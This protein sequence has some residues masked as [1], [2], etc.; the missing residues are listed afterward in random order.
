MKIALFA[1]TL[2]EVHAHNPEQGK[3][4]NRFLCDCLQGVTPDWPEI[5]AI[6]PEIEADCRQFHALGSKRRFGLSYFESGKF[7]HLL[8]SH[9]LIPE[10]TLLTGLA[11]FFGFGARGET[12]DLYVD[13]KGQAFPQ[14]TLRKL[15]LICVVLFLCLYL[16]F[17][18]RIS[19]VFAVYLIL[20]LLTIA[21]GL[22]ILYWMGKRV[23]VQDFDLDALNR[24]GLDQRVVNSVHK[25]TRMDK[26]VYQRDIDTISAQLL[27]EI[28]CLH[29]DLYEFRHLQD[30]QECQQAK[31]IFD[32]KNIRLMVCSNTRKALEGISLRREGPL[33]KSFKLRTFRG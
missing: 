22:Y 10:P 1:E 12:E 24:E 5:A 11:R 28:I 21:Y 13:F 19:M 7:S 25:L 14:Y 32:N 31:Q 16:Y 30:A 29:E 20:S 4:F 33:F 15:T 23:P 18:T 3:I 2:A 17:V 27:N 6:G 9:A 26:C 8:Y